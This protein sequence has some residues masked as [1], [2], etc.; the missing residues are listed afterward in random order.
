MKDI[1]NN[2]QLLHS[3]THT[4]MWAC[5]YTHPCMHVFVCKPYGLIIETKNLLEEESKKLLCRVDV[6]GNMVVVA[7]MCSV[8]CLVASSLRANQVHEVNNDSPWKGVKGE[9]MK[10]GKQCIALHANRRTY[11]RGI[12][13]EEVGILFQCHQYCDKDHCIALSEV[14]SLSPL[15]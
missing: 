13:V 9:E 14:L 3:H 1:A 2:I 12:R 15:Q 11:L 10:G 5:T 4:C 6:N 8:V 7:N